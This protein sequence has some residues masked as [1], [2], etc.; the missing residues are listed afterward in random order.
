MDLYNIFNKATSARKLPKFTKWLA[1]Q[2]QITPTIYSQWTNKLDDIK[3]S[4]CKWRAQ[5]ISRLP[6]FKPV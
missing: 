4:P 3:L 6:T 2:Y 1:S 5:G